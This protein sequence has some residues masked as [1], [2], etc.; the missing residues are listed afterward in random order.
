MADYQKMYTTLFNKVSDV[1]EELQDVQCQTEN[2]YIES[3]EPE[4][5][6]LTPEND[7]DTPDP[8]K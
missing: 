5:V 6:V 7:N 3:P 4:I 1:I 8:E 2:L